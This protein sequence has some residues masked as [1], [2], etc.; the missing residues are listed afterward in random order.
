MSGTEVVNNSFLENPEEKD[1]SIRGRVKSTLPP[2][3][4]SMIQE[5]R[6]GRT[7]FPYN[8]RVKL[9]GVSADFSIDHSTAKYRLE[10]FGE[11]RGYVREFLATIDNDSVV[12]DIGASLGLHTVLASKKA[13]KVI[14]VE[15]DSGIMQDLVRNV[16]G[17]NVDNVV[18]VK[19][20]V[21]NNNGRTLLF[22]GGVESRS[23][24]VGKNVNEH[25]SGVEVEMIRV[26][27]LIQ[28]LIEDGMIL[29]EPDVIKIDVEGYEKEVLKG[30]K[31]LLE[32][33]SMPK[34]IFI[35]LHPEF[36]QQF[37]VTVQEIIGD[38]TRLGY[39]R[40]SRRGRSNELL[41]HFSKRR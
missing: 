12:L 2:G 21:G 16:E 14:A 17:N 34:H 23:P 15:P 1:L 33:G 32:G 3:V 19:K 38:I 35:E 26:D 40:A 9:G 5:I 27:N 39:K 28:Q 24:S 30:M 41:F 18:F 25:T 10:Q 22:T 8:A 20:A 37:G 11:E 4:L 6:H 29:R 36:L 31:G 7:D 13:N